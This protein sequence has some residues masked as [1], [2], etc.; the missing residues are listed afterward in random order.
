MMERKEI[1]V[2]LSKGYVAK[3]Y[4]D[5][6][7]RMKLDRFQWCAQVHKSGKVYAMSRGSFPVAM[8]RLIAKAKKGQ[9]VDH[10][11]GDTLDNR[12]DNLRV[13]TPG[14]N[15]ANSRRE[16]HNIAGFK[17]VTWSKSSRKWAAQIVV[18]GNRFY[19]G[20]FEHKDRAAQAHDRA[21]I[22]FHGEFA[23]LNFPELRDTYRPF[24]PD[25]RLKAWMER[26]GIGD[27]A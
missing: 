14:Q 8:H 7:E 21:A 26:K 2:D 4:S 19:L 27:L 24:H 5:T 25:A 22:Y 16:R 20:V 11:N 10:A 6:W 12:T 9:Y 15:R 18:D 13:C 1:T 3:V 23:G 17:G